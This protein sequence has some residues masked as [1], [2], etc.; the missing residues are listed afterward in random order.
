MRQVPRQSNGVEI[1]RSSKPMAAGYLVH[2]LTAAVAAA[3]EKCRDQNDRLAAD[4]HRRGETDYV[5]AKPHITYHEWEIDGVLHGGF[6]VP[7]SF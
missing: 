6:Y 7:P 5:P 3:K 2:S 1:H 4:W